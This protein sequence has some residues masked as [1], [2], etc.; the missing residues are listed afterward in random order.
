MKKSSKVMLVF[1]CIF[2]TLTALLL[3]MQ[4]FVEIC[5]MNLLFQE[6]ST[7]GDALGG[8]FIYI[9]SILFGSGAIAGAIATI[10]FDIVLLKNEGKKWYAL[11]LLIFSIC[12]I[13]TAV[14]MFFMLPM[15]SEAINNNSSSSVP[16][17]SAY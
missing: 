13:I 1:A 2:A 11:A 4:L 9:Y 6:G 16:S 15:I 8:I 10:P 3:G 14:V 7:F 5:S 17:S 12:A